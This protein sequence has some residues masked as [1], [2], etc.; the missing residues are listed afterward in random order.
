M[1]THNVGGG[2]LQS[3]VNIRGWWREMLNT[4]ERDYDTRS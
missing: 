3:M 2:V 4:R 1:Y